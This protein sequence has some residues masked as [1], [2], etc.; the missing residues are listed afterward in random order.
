M[1]R[2]T[3]VLIVDDDNVSLEIV[4]EIV[5]SLGYSYV[6]CSDYYEAKEIFKNE[7]PFHLVVTDLY[8]PSKNGK[9]RMLGYD[10][11]KFV[12]HESDEN[13]P[14]IVLSSEM[15]PF[16]QWGLFFAGGSLF[17]TKPM[18]KEMLSVKIQKYAQLGRWCQTRDKESKVKLFSGVNNHV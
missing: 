18:K 13:C 15:N 8:M 6:K 10:L 9:M 2:N 5:N 14:T 12:S 7:G 1:K 4:G 3:K 17:V 11:V 16:V